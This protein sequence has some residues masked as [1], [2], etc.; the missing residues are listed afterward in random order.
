VNLLFLSA[1]YGI[2]SK[3]PEAV[4]DFNTLAPND[5]P[6]ELKFVVGADKKGIDR[7][8]L[9]AVKSEP[10]MTH[11]FLF[12]EQDSL[13]AVRKVGGLG[14]R[15]RSG[16][17]LERLLLTAGFPNGDGHV[18]HRGFTRRRDSDNCIMSLIEYWSVPK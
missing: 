3:F 10:L 8:M 14:Q 9:I 1:E 18:G 12:L 2:D 11:S 16:L 7:W 13:E 5:E 6:I 4:A 15:G 17:D